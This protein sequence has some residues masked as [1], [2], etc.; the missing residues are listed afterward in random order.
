MFVVTFWFQVV[1]VGSSMV[2]EISTLPALLPTQISN[3]EDYIHSC[4]L[5]EDHIHS[6][7]SYIA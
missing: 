2:V 6:T 7:S 3:E 5:E 4:L 1:G